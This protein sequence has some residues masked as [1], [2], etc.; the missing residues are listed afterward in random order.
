VT[1]KSRI[2][3]ATAAGLV[4]G[5]AQLCAGAQTS[6]PTYGGTGPSTTSGGPAPAA[7]A[8]APAPGMGTAIPTPSNVLPAAGLGSQAANQPLQAVVGAV[9]LSVGSVP[10]EVGPYIGV[11][12]R[13]QNNTNSPLLL[14]G[15]RAALEKG[16][17]TM[18]CVTNAKVEYSADPPE[19]KAQIAK[20]GLA[21]AVTVGAALAIHDQMV[22]NGP[23]LGRFG[24]D[25]RRREASAER[26]GKRIVWTGDSTEGVIF[27]PTSDVNDINGGNVKVP[28]C[29][30]P[31]LDIRGYVSTTAGTLQT[32]QPQ[33]VPPLNTPKPKAKD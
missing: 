26:F 7:E 2:L 32:P 6:D 5:M 16:S 24:G 11:K 3:T 19:S 27:F 10:V 8:S 15:D 9:E 22:E 28:V 31:S 25:E 17:S 13:V 18:N 12:I 23:I 30:F 4:L 29:T 20:N 14:D 33:T 21:A 1:P